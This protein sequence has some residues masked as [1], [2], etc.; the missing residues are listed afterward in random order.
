MRRSTCPPPRSR[1]DSSAPNSSA[2]RRRALWPRRCK[3][4]ATGTADGS[5]RIAFCISFRITVAREPV[6]REQRV[7]AEIG[8]LGL[9]RVQFRK[10][11][12]Q[13]FMVGKRV[14]KDGRAG[15]MVWIAAGEVSAFYVFE[16]VDELK[17]KL[18]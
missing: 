4:R 18:D 14:F 11:G 8:R 6:V 9:E 1:L 17:K 13:E 16:S 2:Y 15:Y 7:R 3:R 5:F 10:L 12:S